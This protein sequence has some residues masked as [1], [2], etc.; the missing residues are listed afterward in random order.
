MILPISTF[1]Q[2]STFQ[3]IPLGETE[4]RELIIGKDSVVVMNRVHAKN[5]SLERVDYWYL[6]QNDKL[7]E[8]LLEAYRDRMKGYENELS[9]AMQISELKDDV[10]SEEREKEKSYQKTIDLQQ[11]QLRRQRNRSWIVIGSL[12]AGIIAI[13]SL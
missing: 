10:L 9:L 5:L 13:S 1:S 8:E 6:K 3:W 7:Q 2:E 4:V 12:A 11:S